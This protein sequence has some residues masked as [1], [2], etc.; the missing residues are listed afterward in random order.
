[1]KRRILFVA[2]GLAAALVAFGQT[3]AKAD[4]CGGYGGYYGGGY[5]GYYGG[6]AAAPVYRAVPNYGYGY[7][8]YYGGGYG[9]YHNHGYYGR[10]YGSSIRVRTPGFSFGLYR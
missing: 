3:S 5:G 2:L 1:M 7:G 4:H 6:V 9:H 10:G 8:N